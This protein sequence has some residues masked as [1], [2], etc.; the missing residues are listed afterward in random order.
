[1]RNHWNGCGLILHEICHL[2]HQQVLGL[3]CE[4]VK[5]IYARAQQSGRYESVLRRDWAGKAGGDAD[6]SYCMIDHKEFFAE[7]SV[8]YWANSYRDLDKASSDTMEECTPPIT[9]PT[10]LARFGSH[11]KVLD[12][13]EDNPP[14]ILLQLVGALKKAFL[15]RGREL[16]HCNKF[17]PF[18]SGQLQYYDPMQSADM[19]TIW[20]DIAMWEDPKEDRVYC[21]G[22][23]N[24]QWKNETAKHDLL[25]VFE[26]P[27]KA[28]VPNVISDTVEL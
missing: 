4:R 8:T 28:A 10:V 1:M 6:L 27:E 19:E 17:Y 20:N 24:A 16:P 14:N 2:I 18:T 13:V 9:D 15:P 11:R 26:E 12:F 21:S 23:W 7:M 25:S 22:C 3:D 5:I